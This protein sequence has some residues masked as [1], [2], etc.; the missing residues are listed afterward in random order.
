M[1]KLLSEARA[2]QIKE[3]Q[4]HCISLWTLPISVFATLKA[5]LH[6]WPYHII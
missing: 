5:S 3:T 2:D 6:K 4:L 1:G